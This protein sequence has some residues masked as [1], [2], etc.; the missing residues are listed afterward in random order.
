MASDMWD[1][2]TLSGTDDEINSWVEHD[3][4]RIARQR[5]ASLR[6]VAEA[7]A[8][9]A[10]CMD[11]LTQVSARVAEQFRR[12]ERGNRQV[13]SCRV[14]EVVVRL[15]Q[16]TDASITVSLRWGPKLGLTDAERQLMR[17]YQRRPRRLFRYPALVVGHEYHE[18][19]A[20]LD[21]ADETLRLGS[22][23]VQPL[24]Q[25]LASPAVVDRYLADGIVRPPLLRSVH[26][27]SDGYKERSR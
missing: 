3:L 21:G 11:S 6:A 18:L 23:S 14:H 9:V 20:V 27:R 1:R 12:A 25:Y 26:H 17:S 5:D 13:R 15:H 7:N 4:S 10:R 19:S 24:S 8:K 16:P 22:G 2:A